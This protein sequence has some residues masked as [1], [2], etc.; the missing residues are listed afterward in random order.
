MRSHRSVIKKRSCR[1][2]PPS[3]TDPTQ[4][5]QQGKVIPHDTQ[6]QVIKSSLRVRR[7]QMSRFLRADD[8]VDV[9]NAC[10]K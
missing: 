8:N 4:H 7:N 5:Y 6:I 10:L 1:T 9:W 3:T 2:V